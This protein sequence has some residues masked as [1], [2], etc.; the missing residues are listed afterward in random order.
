MIYSETY[1]SIND[2]MSD[3]NIGARK[4]KNV[5]DH[6]FILYAVINSVVRGDSKCIDIQVY[7]IQKA[8]DALWLNDTFN[9]L[10]DSLPQ[11][12]RDNSISLLY[13]TNLTNMVAV[14]TPVGL[15]KR[16]NMPEII[17]QGGSGGLCYVPIR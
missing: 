9:D 2:S 10:F 17:Q 6:L 7:D 1:D 5:R 11:N 3:S 13:K 15:T 4:G 16:V 8:F 14:K 12:K